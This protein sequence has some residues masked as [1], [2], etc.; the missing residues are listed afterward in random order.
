VKRA[1]LLLLALAAVGVKAQTFPVELDKDRAPITKTVNGNCLIKNARILTITKGV[2]ENGMILVRNGKIAQ[3]GTNLQVPLD[4]YPVIDAK[5]MIVMPG[6]IDTHVHRGMEGTNEGSESITAEASIRYALNPESRNIWQSLASGETTGMVLHGSANPIGGESVVVKFKYRHPYAEL[7]IPDA[8]RQ[9]KFAL[10]ENVTRKNNPTTAT[11]VIRFP[12]TRMGVEATYRRAF[13]EAKVYRAKKNAGENIK[14]DVR[15]E[16]LADIL[17]RKVWVQCHSYRADEMLMMVRLSEEYGFHLNM[18]HALEAY[19][20]APEMAKAGVGCGM[21]FDNWAAKIEM[22]DGIPYNAAICTDAGVTVSV[23]TDGTGGTTALNVDAGKAMRYGGVSEEN[24]LKM[25]TINPAKQLGIDHRTG[26]IEV[27]KDA[28]LVMWSGNPLSTYAKPM[29]TMIEGEIY[30][31]RRDMFNVDS[32][33][34][35]KIKL[36]GFKYHAAP[37]PLKKARAYA[38]TDATV[39]PVSGPMMEHCTVIIEDGKITSVGERVNIPSDA[40]RV[41]G[42]GKRV[43]P[44]FIDA[45]STIGL[46]EVS[47]IVQ[48]NDGS[49]NGAY[50]PDMRAKTVLFVES[51]YLG[52]ARTNGVTHTFTRPSGGIIPGQAV[53]AATWGYTTE[54][55]GAYP[56]DALVINMQGGGGFNPPDEIFENLC[57]DAD[58]WASLGLYW[59]DGMIPPPSEF[60]HHDDEDLQGGAAGQG[61][62]QGGRG[63]G[64]GQGRGQTGGGGAGQQQPGGGQGGAPVQPATPTVPVQEYIDGAREYMRNPTSPRN[65]RYEAMLPYLR[66]EK[67]VVIRVRTSANIRAAVAFAKKN[68]F[69]VILSG[70]DEAWRETELLKRE[71]IPVLISPAGKVCLTANVTVNDWDPYDT[72]YALPG[73]LAKAGV[74]F[75]FESGTNSEVQNLGVRVGQSCGYGLTYDQALKALTLDAAKIFGVDDRIGSIQ[76]G[77]IADLIITEGDPLDTQCN[78]VYAFIEGQP[79]PMTSK[80]TMLRDKYWGRFKD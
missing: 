61:G 5:G 19:K 49:E 39:Y 33:S 24:A 60:H 48:W 53:L 12:R 23:N 66:G 55:I 80:H 42:R 34:M 37:A 59:L 44:G 27:G 8:P 77:K 54:Q 43:Y 31:E 28:D 26:S 76:K 30:F 72:P 15:L 38:I 57:S 10:G 22:F 67:P 32:I 65:L 40:I 20:I 25:L 35:N 62:G 45:G 2:I 63:Q 52:T 51:A 73:L 75:A 9:C 17:D 78:V 11:T 50:Q 71:R 18:Q 58:D 74:Q 46:S 16:T 1:A 47:G 13:E 4:N 64:G 21:F 6:I 79:A 69:K 36:D 3:V 7:P 70:A 68:H 41:D 29:M 14:T 56:D